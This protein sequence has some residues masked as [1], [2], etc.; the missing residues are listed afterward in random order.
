MP[1]RLALI[2]LPAVLAAGCQKAHTYDPRPHAG[3]TSANKP[4]GAD[5]ERPLPEDYAWD[6]SQPPATDVPIEFVHSGKEDWKNLKTYWTDPSLLGVSAL[7]L[8]GVAPLAA[9]IK[10]AVKIKT[11]L[12][13]DD[14]LGYIPSANPPTRGKWDLG[15]RLFFDRKWLTAAGDQSCASCHNP[16]MA[17]TDGRSRV[18]GSY[19][20]PT[21][22][23]CVYNTHQFWDGRAIYLEEVVQRTLVDEREPKDSATFRH[24]WPG[25]IGRL[26][27]SKSYPARFEKVFGV[28]PTQDGV[29]M[30]LATYMRTILAGNSLHDR[31]VQEKN[32]KAAPALTAAHYEA[33]LDDAALK[34]LKRDPAKK[35]ATAEDLL[36]GH[37][38]FMGKAG[39]VSCHTASNGH[40]SDSGFHNIG[41]GADEL[42]K[43]DGQWGRFRHAPYGE[44]HR[45]LKGAFK[46]PTLRTL[47]RTSPYFHTGEE[48][49]LEA[50]VRF[51]IE[52]TPGQPLNRFLDPRLA[53]EEVGAHRDL[54][55]NEYDLKT[56]VLFLEALNGD[57]V[58]PAITTAPK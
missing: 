40:F 52:T 9:K 15:R 48:R 24:V 6:D 25:V 37:Q 49:S 10:P 16:S 3:R 43:P 12:G 35:A 4:D 22:V 26:R 58:D 21:L 53:G 17:Y 14:P 50:V 45:F 36:H 47:K 32:R 33:V 2:L 13:L 11:P 23:N 5:S 34:A 30:A 29:G 19:N 18:P 54:R 55:L 46:T 27:A 31:A 56:L 38:L 44:R 1:S 7:G 41:V 51:H 20:T 57:E 39:C 42:E 8:P 28:P